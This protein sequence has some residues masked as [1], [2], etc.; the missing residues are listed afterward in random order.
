MFSES[1]QLTVLTPDDGNLPSLSPLE[2]EDD[3]GHGILLL[4]LEHEEDVLWG[5]LWADEVDSLNLALWDSSFRVSD[6]GSGVGRGSTRVM[7]VF[8]R[9]Q[10]RGFPS[11]VA[12]QTS[13]T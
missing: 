13:M 1:F 2:G 4:C 12:C 3:H 8:V 10:R 9:L 7:S 6:R 5:G 11:A